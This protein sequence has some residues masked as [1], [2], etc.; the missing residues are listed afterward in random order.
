MHF[1]AHLPPPPDDLPYG[2][3]LKTWLL[4]RSGIADIGLIYPLGY[5]FLPNP[6]PNPVAPIFDLFV[7]YKYEGDFRKLHVHRVVPI[8]IALDHSLS[9]TV[10]SVRRLN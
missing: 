8:I 1:E 10:T 9:M 6:V 2:D 3:K 7:R 4:N 5:I